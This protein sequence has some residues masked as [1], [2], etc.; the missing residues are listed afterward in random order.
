MGKF[1][2]T[3]KKS[4][5][6]ALNATTKGGF[7]RFK[8]G[9]GK[10]KRLLILGP[11]S[12][13][14]AVFTATYHEKFGAS[15]LLGK[16]ASPAYTGDVDKISDI[17]W[18]LRDKYMESTNIKKKDLWKSFMP[19]RP[20][21]VSV[22]DLDNVELG[23]QV[24]QMGGTVSELV[25]EEFAECDGIMSICDFDEGRILRVRSNRKPKLK[26]RYTCEFLEETANLIEDGVLD[27]DS[28]S[29][30]ADKMYDLSKLQPPFNQEAFDKYFTL[31]TKSAAAI[32]VN[33]DDF[34]GDEDETESEIE[35]DDALEESDELAENESEE[36]DEVEDDEI[37]TSF[38][39]EEPEEKPVAKKKAAKKKAA[40]RRSK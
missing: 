39:D 36:V 2:M 23:P 31:L 29:E 9:E 6:A 20:S 35:D 4:Q 16:A 19:K 25:L 8:F 30:L 28:I 5:E 24:Y 1:L 22:L 26:R 21:F 12:D 27:D 11:T 7:A 13:V 32:G 3:S 14:S 40:R 33:I 15:K 10:E 17:G 37:D 38:E 18:K 34:L